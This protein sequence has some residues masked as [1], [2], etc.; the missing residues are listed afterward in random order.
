M[1]LSELHRHFPSF[2][3]PSYAH[4]T[5]FQCKFSL[6]GKEFDKVCEYTQHIKL[7]SNT[8]NYRFACGVPE[9]SRQYA[10]LPALKAHMYRDHKAVTPSS[11]SGDNLVCTPLACDICAVQCES[12]SSLV[13]H[14]RSHLRCGLHVE[15]PFRGCNARFSVLSSFASHV[16]KKH[17]NDCVEH[18][19]PC[20]VER[21]DASESMR[22]SE[23]YVSNYSDEQEVPLAV[24]ESLFLQNITLFYLKLQAKLLLPA[25]VIQAII[26]GYQDV[27]DFSLTNMLNTLSQKLTALGIPEATI[28]DIIDE[29]R[30]DDILTACNSGLSTDQRRKTAFKKHFNYVEP[31]SH[32]LGINEKGK[33]SFAQYVPIK[34]TLAALFK[35]KSMQEQYA[36]T[37]CKRSPQGILQDVDDGKGVQ[38]NPLFK[39]DPSS[40]GIILYQD[41]FEVVN[42]LGSSKKKH[43]ILSVYLTLTDIL[44]H[45]RSAIDNM[46]LVLLCKEQD[47]R[48]FGMDKVFEPLIRDLKALEE[49]GVEINNGQAVR[50]R[51]C[52]ISGDNLGSHSIGGFV[53]NF[54][55]SHYFCRYC[56]VKRSQFEGSPLVRGNS[57][58]PE[59][60]LKHV[61]ELGK[62][63]LISE[64]GVKSDS[65]FNQLA[66]FHV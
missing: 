22:E 56:D 40:L 50:G 39:A 28:V 52:A 65:P 43:K 6:C 55:V 64:C 9:C 38:C 13:I 8:A 27:H 12:S 54:S 19:N 5:M 61:Q 63:D 23:I 37:R 57:R 2:H 7:H 30:K 49:S 42:P 45:N 10:K 3:F 26:D 44:P 11:S 35:N 59:S 1:L 17:R 48:Y 21:P 31:V 16:S 62:G 60:F 34:E 20:S 47:F 14:L 66:F 25:P 24:D 32:L 4:L 36:A 41:A 46:Q 58:T 33:E 18:E 53:E 15:C 51:L 29:I